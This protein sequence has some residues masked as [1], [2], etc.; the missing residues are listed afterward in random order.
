[1]RTKDRLW[2]RFRH[3][4]QRGAATV[5]IWL[6]G[7]L[8]VAPLVGAA[9]PNTS[10][11]YSRVGAITV[12]KTILTANTAKDGTGTVVIVFTADATNGG[13]V[14]NVVFQ[15]TGSTTTPTVARIFINN[16]AT[17]TVASNN[18]YWR[19]V[20]IPQ[21]TLS[22]LASMPATVFAANITLPP[23]Y[24]LLITIGT[25]VAVNIAITVEAGAY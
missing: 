20:T 6:V 23:G 1:M 21:A 24:Q 13:R 17:N 7:L 5:L 22:E 9:V 14:G 11:I 15:P 18:S 10:P 3:R 2:R 4:M 16:G 8:G 12:G 25:T 19:D